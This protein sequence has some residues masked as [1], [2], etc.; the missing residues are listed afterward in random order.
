M[1]SIINNKPQLIW[2]LIQ[3]VKSLSIIALPPLLNLR[4]SILRKRMKS[5]L[6]PRSLMPQRIIR[7]IYSCKY[8]SPLVMMPYTWELC[9]WDHQRVNLQELSSI[10]VP[11]ILPSPLHSAM[12]RLQETSSSRSTTHCQAPSFREI[13]WT[14][15]AKP[16]HMTW[17]SLT[18]TRF[19]PKHHPSSPM[20]QPSYKDS[21]GKIM[22]ASNLSKEQP[23]SWPS[24][25][26]N[27]RTTSAHTSS[28]WLCTNLKVLAR[29]QTVSLVYLLTKIWARRSFTTSG[30]WRI[31]ELLIMPW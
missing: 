22:P 10:L 7:T 17:K 13:N 15:D 4:T 5:N 31:M 30:Q 2:P 19:F 29:T 21:S 25:K 11:N 8:P 16:K 20:V 1:K 26:C 9:T 24:S 23:P 6:S 28:S 12:T 27:W 3:K 14:K 18:P